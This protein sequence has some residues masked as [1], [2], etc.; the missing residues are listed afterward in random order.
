MNIEAYFQRIAYDGPQAPDATT[1]HGLQLAHLLAVPFENLDISLGHAIVLDE[2]ALFNKIITRR[3]GGICYE[4][5]G[6]FAALLGSLGFEVAYLSASDAHADGAYGPA[7]D[8]LALLVPTRDER[9]HT[10]RWL[11]DVGWGDT[12]CRPLALDTAAIQSDGIGQYRLEQDGSACVV[13]QQ[14]ADQT[15]EANYRV[16]SQPYALSDFFAM[17]TFHQTSPA[18]PWTQQRLCTRLTPEGRITLTG[19]HLTVTAHGQ[20]HRTPVED[21][22]MFTRL[23]EEHFGITL[24]LE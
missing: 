14:Q 24:S 13:W 2:E 17:C 18:S 1:L 10:T 21:D 11:V 20:R 7:F 22:A 3:R 9:G 8:H 12:F 6:L 4:L 5:N 23:A 19:K 16:S 15:W